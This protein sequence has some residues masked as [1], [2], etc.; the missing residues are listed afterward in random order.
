[1]LQFFKNLLIFGEGG[2]GAGAAPAASA[3]GQ[4]ADESGRISPDAG[5]SRRLTRAERRA[6]LEATLKAEQAQQEQQAS[7]AQVPVT[8]APAEQ[9]PEDAFRGLINGQYKEQFD[10]IMTGRFAK[11]K[12]TENELEAARVEIARRDELLAQLAKEH[13]IEPGEDGKVNLEAI[14]RYRKQ[15]RVE[16]Y[17]LENGVSDEL[18]KKHVSM[19]DELATQKQQ[20][21]K[22]QDEQRERENYAAYLRIKGAAEEAQKTFPDMDVAATVNDPK[23][24]HLIKVLSPA[25]AYSALHQMDLTSKAMQ[26]AVTTTRAAAASTIQ[27]GMARPVEGGLGR[28]APAKIQANVQDKAW[29]DQVKRDARRGIY[30]EF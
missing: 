4:A 27:A 11:A 30:R 8:N 20:I 16:E 29:R 18:A 9:S 7:Q 1:M 21:Q 10:K 14:E 3:D 15:A 19:L 23:F 6:R 26:Y 22:M 25:A 24:A 13:G 28:A 17:A 2:D 12:Q 5:E